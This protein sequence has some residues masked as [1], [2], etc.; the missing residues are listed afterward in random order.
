MSAANV[1]K[2]AIGGVA[3][4]TLLSVGACSTE[5]VDTGKRGVTIQFGEPTG[6][7][8]EGLHFVNPFTT[9]VKQLS[10]RQ[11]KWTSETNVYTEDVQPANVKYTLTYSLSPDKVLETYQTVG[12]GWA[13]AQIPQ[14]TLQAIKDVFIS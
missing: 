2:L 7:L 10:V 13:D 5:T 9:S 1:I 3:A 12:E 14:V 4:V 6:T 11:L 8:D